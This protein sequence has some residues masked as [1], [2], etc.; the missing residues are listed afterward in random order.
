MRT[1]KTLRMTLF[2]WLLALGLALPAAGL[3]QIPTDGLVARYGLDV[4]AGI[5]AQLGKETLELEREFNR[6]AGF[7]AADDRLP[8]WMTRE[9][10]PPHNTVFDVP[11]AEMDAI[12][13]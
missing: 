10:L 13:D 11:E 5:L 3:A 9:Q 6:L 12:F 7:T 1:A 2:P 4:D 8:E